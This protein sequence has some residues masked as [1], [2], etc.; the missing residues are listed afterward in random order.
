MGI[1]IDDWSFVV[2]NFFFGMGVGKNLLND[3]LWLF[4]LMGGGV[5][6]F[7]LVG[8]LLM[9]VD[10]VEVNWDVCCGLELVCESVCWDVCVDCCSLWFVCLFDLLMM[11]LVG[12]MFVV[13]CLVLI[14][15]VGLFVFIGECFMFF[16][17]WVLFGFCERDDVG[18]VVGWY[19]IGLIESDMIVI[20]LSWDLSEEINL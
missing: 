20:W 5:D 2:L 14:G 11:W 19:C 16:E 1:N 7:D 6:S 13:G 17:L 12:W 18:L 15:M 4:D 8:W 10:F 3:M 9:R